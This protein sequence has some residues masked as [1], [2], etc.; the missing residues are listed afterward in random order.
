M[1]VDAV[2]ARG[3]VGLNECVDSVVDTKKRGSLE[4][5]RLKYSWIDRLESM[6]REC[7]PITGESE[8]RK[9][10]GGLEGAGLAGRVSSVARCVVVQDEWFV[11]CSNASE[12]QSLVEGKVLIGDSVSH[13]RPGPDG[14]ARFV[15]EWYS[16]VRRASGLRKNLEL[17]RTQFQHRDIIFNIYCWLK[18]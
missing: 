5:V 15:V 10:V 1:A 11:E 6:T 9:S 16:G 8:Q 3:E 12:C 2:F 4:E 14:G 17:T 7:E 13:G 18:R